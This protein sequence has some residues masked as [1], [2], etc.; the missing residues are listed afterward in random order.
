ML[1]KLSINK[2]YTVVVVIIMVMILGIISY[3]NMSL[4][5]LPSINLPYAVVIT[6]CP[7][8]SPEAVELTVTS[9]LEQALA[10]TSNV[11]QLK[12]ISSE[13]LSY[14]ILEFDTDTNMDS[15]IVE[16]RENL[17]LVAA[18]LPEG[19]GT[20]VIMKLNPDML[21]IMT[22]SVSLEG[23]TDAEA[24]RFINDKIIPELKSIE[25]VAS[26]S[27]TGLIENYIN[28]TITES[29]V[30]SLNNRLKGHYLKRA[31]EEIRV[32]ARTE[33][34]RQID[35]GIEAQVSRL[36]SLG[37][38][39]SAAEELLRATRQDLLDG[40]EA[41]VDEI[42]QSRLEEIEVPDL[43]ITA[44]ML[45]KIL[46]AQNLSLPAGSAVSENG[47]S[48]VV[49]VGDAFKNLDEL[50]SMVIMD[51]PDFGKVR[52][53]DIA[54]I[55]ATD[56]TSRIY[57][58]VNDQYAIMLSIQK[59]PGYSTTDVTNRIS[60][61]VLEL[62]RTYKGFVFESLMDQGDYVNMMIDTVLDNLLYGSLLAIVVLLVFLRRIRPTFI[63]AASILISVVTT[64]VLMYFSGI[65]LNVISMGG[66]ALGIGML[67]DNSIVV[68]ENI[69]KMISEGKPVKEAAL[70]GA[71]EVAG[72]IISSTLTTVVVFLPIAF[73]RGITRQIFT[74]M[75]LTIAFSLSASLL[76]SL[77]LVPAAS[78]FS[79]G[80][81]L[82]AGMD[83][84]RRLAAVYKRL[85]NKALTC[86][87]ATIALC[88][89]LFALSILAALDFDRVLFPDMDTGAIELRITMPGHYSRAE[90]FAALDDFY[91]ALSS[92]EEI[93][94]IGIMYTGDSSDAALG[95]MNLITGST[96]TVNLLLADKR[97]RTASE[98][99]DEIRSLAEGY[100]FKV[101]IS[102]INQYVNML[103]GGEVV[104]NVFGMDTDDLRQAAMDVT[105]IISSIEGTADVDNGLGKTN[106]ELR[107][108]VDKAAAMAEGVTIFQ[109]FNAV[110]KALAEVTA[111][112]KLKDGDT[113]YQITI[114]DARTPRITE[115]SLSDIIA[116]SADGKNV[117]IGDIARID[118]AEGFS[119]IHRSD[120]ERYVSVSASLKPGYSIGKVSKI[121][122]DRLNAHDFPAGIRWEA[123]GEQEMLNDTYKDLY[124]ILV[125]AIVFIYLV[126]VAQFQSLLSPFIILF[127]IPLAFTGG[128][129]ALYL[130]RLPLSIVA[131]IG[132]VLL[133]GVVVNNG[134]LF[135]DCANQLMAQ[136]MGKKEAL[137]RTAEVRLRPILMTA[138]TTIFALLT[139]V[140]DRSR[141]SEILRPM[142][143]TTIGGLVYA[144]ALTLFLIPAFYMVF[145][146][147][148]RSTD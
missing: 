83:F 128:F 31:E 103:S 146:K 6:A 61:K 77:T 7:G 22:A 71:K 67:V 97:Q 96:A 148:N 3:T 75:A 130:T 36:A 107:I 90:A 8:A 42:V 1:S 29:K 27:A 51:I 13:H 74:D 131:L 41:R 23:K 40:V 20:P 134:I 93:K 21:P 136:G 118:R 98:I 89:V 105:D 4:D 101:D 68:I 133:V 137:L 145:V 99:A 28:V 112:T 87:Y 95:M 49:R 140:F 122:E 88:A 14:I 111:I 34:I 16:M 141:G 43:D 11:K 5:L 9:V 53:E 44:E 70:L 60:R 144:T 26:V 126:M 73:V 55:I 66:L 76:T 91:G 80:K 56:N 19:T 94:T 58:R 110:N 64:F 2:P 123:A 25:G 63:V 81:E 113:V 85:L 120:Q 52:L 57:S 82:A 116:V 117:R 127:T 65:T 135:V 54:E 138:L 47:S 15:A 109:V 50:R 78:S 106:R 86:K 102:D 124:V 30:N 114:H 72:P 32:A 100:D 143:V 12:S 119:S 92:N 84:S 59:Q 104:I 39:R 139:M 115:R 10:S 147:E 18:Y 129:L 108:T 79:L 62:S 17:D 69:Y 35:E 45:G 125:L 46:M 121:L 132:L 142:A 33:I 38:K 24:A 37:I 48:L